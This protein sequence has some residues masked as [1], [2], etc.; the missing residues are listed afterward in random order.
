MPGLAIGGAVEV[1]DQRGL[2]GR[3]GE[4]R[5][6]EQVV[7][8]LLPVPVAVEAA[9]VVA[10]MVHENEVGALPLPVIMVQ[11]EVPDLS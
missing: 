8:V 5:I 2:H 3:D 7:H 10:L 4:Q 6:A 11:M 1:Q 9:T